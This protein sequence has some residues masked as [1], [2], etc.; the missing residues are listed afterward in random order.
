MSGLPVR[1]FQ[2][3]TNWQSRR[4]DKHINKAM[5]DG[6]LCEEQ[7]KASTLHIHNY[8]EE[9]SRIG[10]NGLLLIGPQTHFLFVMNGRGQTTITY[11][12][13][14]YILLLYTKGLVA[15]Q[16]VPGPL[17]PLPSTIV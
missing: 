10:L 11:M 6:H 1:Q 3:P 8:N 15:R 7:R 9:S 4:E 12:Y 14:N 5:A 13:I 2:R 17:C 16:G